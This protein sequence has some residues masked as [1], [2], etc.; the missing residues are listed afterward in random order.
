M[1]KGLSSIFGHIDLSR[2]WAFVPVLVSFALLK[3][4]FDIA[5][6]AVPGVG[7]IVQFVTE[8]F[9]IIYAATAL[10]LT[11]DKWVNRGM[12]KYFLGMVVAFISEAF[13][14]IGWL[15]LSV[16][17]AFIFYGFVLLDRASQ[18]QKSAEEEPAE[19][20]QTPAYAA[21]AGSEN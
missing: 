7:M 3:D 8:I 20:T 9:L 14:G 13:P 2:D 6:A 4:I 18:S 11:G 12:T 10:F 15:P 1:I 17:E 5:F 19:N 21:T 16:I